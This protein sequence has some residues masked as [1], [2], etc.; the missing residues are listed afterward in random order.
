MVGL[1]QGGA[2]ALERARG[3][4]DRAASEGRYVSGKLAAPVPAP[5]KLLF[6]GLNYEDHLI[7]SGKSDKPEEPF[8]FAKL[9]TS[10]VGAGQ[11]IV[12]PSRESQVD[13]EAELAVV[14]GQKARGVKAEDAMQYVFGYT[15]V[16][17]VSCRDI[18]FKDNQVT[19]GKGLDTF[20]PMGPDL[21]TADEVPDPGG[22]RI[23]TRVNREVR[24]DSSTRY[25]IHSIPKLI[26]FLSR[27]ISLLPGDIIATGTP[28][29]VG[30]FRR[31]PDFLKPGDVVE[32]E[33]EELGTLRNPCVAAWARNPY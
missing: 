2:A 15:I 7:E 30:A 23:A 13:Y 21:V 18:Q 29:G 10:I 14:I 26:E 31:P 20:C 33:I 6:C 19:L 32:V 22:L 4:A 3:H 5:Q 24:Q 1:I 17:D 8:F 27:N 12:I 16:N 9:P 25:L 28:A 11:P